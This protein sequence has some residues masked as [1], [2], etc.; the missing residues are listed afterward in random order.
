MPAAGAR[1]PPAA[2]L[3]GGARQIPA[4]SSQQLAM[5]LSCPSCLVCHQAVQ[6]AVG[7]E[8]SSREAPQGAGTATDQRAAAAATKNP[9]FRCIQPFAAAAGALPSCLAASP[10]AG[11]FCRW[12]QQWRGAARPGGL[13]CSRG[14]GAPR[15]AAAAPIPAAPEGR[16]QPPGHSPPW[17]RQLPNT[18]P[19]ACQPPR[20][21]S[22]CSGPPNKLQQGSRTAAGARASDPG[23]VRQGLPPRNTRLLVPVAQAGALGQLGAV[24]LLC[25]EGRGESG[26]QQVRGGGGKGH[27]RGGSTR[28]ARRGSGRV[29]GPAWLPPACP[30]PSRRPSGLD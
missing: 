19:W 12:G 17:A 21:H 4:G 11:T 18:L 28:A 27:G 13:V 30:P 10:A 6:Q 20:Q 8:G 9:S 14:V 16:H 24:V 23:I 22:W 26:G 2:R 1:R 29:G 3:A 15:G 7:H 5:F 25:R